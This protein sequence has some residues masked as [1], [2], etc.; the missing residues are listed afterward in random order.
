[1]NLPGIKISK[2]HN[3]D[4]EIK[5]FKY[6][7]EFC[8]KKIQLNFICKHS[9][10]SKNIFIHFIKK[11]VGNLFQEQVLKKTYQTINK[12]DF[13]IFTHSTLGHEAVAKRI[14][15]LSLTPS[16]PWPAYRG[17]MKNGFYWSN[18]LN[19]KKI[20]NKIEQL[21]KLNKNTWLKKTSK[22]SSRILN[23]SPKN[24]I[25]KKIIKNLLNH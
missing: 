18:S 22:K 4:R 14:K 21:M 2:Y 13:I 9:E 6:L 11:K 8:K 19:R 24:L 12:S 20:Q 16:F 3:Q 23:Y 5:I 7:I 15:S 25:A 17:F 10:K 1:M